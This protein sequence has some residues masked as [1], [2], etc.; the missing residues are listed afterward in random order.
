MK[1]LNG[2]KKTEEVISPSC[3]YLKIDGKKYTIE[4]RWAASYGVL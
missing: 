1:V 4:W 3:G 2:K